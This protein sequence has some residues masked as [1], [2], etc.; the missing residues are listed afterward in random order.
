[1]DLFLRDAE[2]LA[3]RFCALV[4]EYLVED[5]LSAAEA[6]DTT[7]TQV[8]ALRY[9]ARHVP[10]HVGEMSFGL[11]ISPPAATKTVDRLV[12]KGLVDRREDPEDRRQHLLTLTET[13]E[14][15]LSR[16][17]EQQELRLG[18]ILE[19]MAEADRKAFVKGLRGFMTAAFMTENALVTRTCERC[20]SDCFESCII[21]QAHLALYNQA[22][23]PV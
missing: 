13:G 1:M 3:L 5:A 6:S 22:I 23:Q 12:Q 2:K 11:A 7:A 14:A 18:E 17:R 20:G 21:N 16:V 4:Q 10:A 9:I 15:L 19:R 8:S